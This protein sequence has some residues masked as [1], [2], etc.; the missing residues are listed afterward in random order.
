[1][2]EGWSRVRC[3]APGAG[4]VSLSEDAGMVPSG[5]RSLRRELKA[6]LDD[7]AR[8]AYDSGRQ[9]RRKSEEV[10]KENSEVIDDHGEDGLDL[11]FFGRE[12]RNELRNMLERF[13]GHLKKVLRTKRK[14]FVTETNAALK[15]INQKIGNAMKKRQ[16]QRQEFYRRYYQR[17]L[18]LFCE[19]NG[20]V[21]KTKKQ[22]EK[23][24]SLFHKQRNLF[25]KARAVQNQRLRKI[26]NLYDQFLKDV[27]S[28]EE[29]QKCLATN[30]GKEFRQEMA[31][32]RM[33]IMVDVQRQELEN[34]RKAVQFLLL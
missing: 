11:G 18:T 3:R 25:Q 15:A 6:L 29:N 30:D 7:Q 9:G 8:A 32:L 14:Q 2:A 13:Q 33:K 20:D 27:Q 21:Q 10:P 34:I 1:M 12:M 28:F 24:I 22:E 19:W 17:F 16:E 4:E 26:K 5:R 23:L 31:R